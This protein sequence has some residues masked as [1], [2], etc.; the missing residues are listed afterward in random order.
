M[1]DTQPNKS[2]GAGVIPIAIIFG[3]LGF[4]LG[5]LASDLLPMS[6]SQS[7]AIPENISQAAAAEVND[8][9][10][11][12]EAERDDLAEDVDA[13]ADD[14]VDQ[15]EDVADDAMD[16]LNDAANDAAGSGN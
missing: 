15:A 4:G 13:A 10:E 14:L 1:T 2:S 3:V 16:A 6:Q 8:R 5:F 12:P 7:P 11:F 9:D